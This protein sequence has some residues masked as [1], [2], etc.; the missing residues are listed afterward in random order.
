MYSSRTQAVPNTLL[1]SAKWESSRLHIEKCF[2]FSSNVGL[3]FYGT[4]KSCIQGDQNAVKHFDKLFLKSK[5]FTWRAYFAWVENNSSFSYAKQLCGILK[6][7]RAIY[8]ERKIFLRVDHAV[9]CYWKVGIYIGLWLKCICIPY[10]RHFHVT[11]MPEDYLGFS[12]HKK[13]RQ[14]P[15]AWIA[16]TSRTLTF[17]LLRSHYTKQYYSSK[18]RYGMDFTEAKFWR[19]ITYWTRPRGNTSTAKQ[20]LESVTFS[21]HCTW[22]SRR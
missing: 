22:V 15:F 21:Q 17:F 3:C 16:W 19:A 7:H 2:Q 1:V 5:H 4:R 11:R 12:Q 13:F 9:Q 6:T 20:L 14:V 8:M 10:D 18:P